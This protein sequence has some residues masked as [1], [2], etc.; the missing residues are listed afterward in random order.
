VD[1]PSTDSKTAVVKF[2]CGLKNYKHNKPFED[3]AIFGMTVK[4][5]RQHGDKDY[6]KFEYEKSLAPNHVHVKFPFIMQKFHEWYYLLCVYGL[7]CIEAKIPGDIF[8]TLDFDLRVKLAELHTIFH[9]KML[10]IT[11]MSV[12]CM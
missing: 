6:M 9:L 10:D 8:N 7:N 1:K 4:E 11:M 3:S 2:F 5:F 12:W